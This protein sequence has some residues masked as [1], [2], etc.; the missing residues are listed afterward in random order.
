[1]SV[2]IAIVEY[3]QRRGTARIV[4]SFRIY[5]GIL[6]FLQH[7]SPSQHPS[8]SDVGV[9]ALKAFGGRATAPVARRTLKGAH[10]DNA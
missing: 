9:S 1:M 2:T 10:S 4:G 3:T 6:E 5:A 8:I 7:F